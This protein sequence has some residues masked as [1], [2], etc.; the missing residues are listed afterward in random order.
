MRMYEEE[1]TNN[2]VK[3]MEFWHL[4]NNLNIIYVCILFQECLLACEETLDSALAAIDE[5]RR[6]S[7]LNFF[8]HIYFQKLNAL[9]RVS[10][11]EEAESLSD[12]PRNC[13]LIRKVSILNLKKKKNLIMTFGY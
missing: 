3:V 2:T 12:L 11:D 4:E 10:A 8:E 1:C 9:R 6:I 5:K 13:V 7:L